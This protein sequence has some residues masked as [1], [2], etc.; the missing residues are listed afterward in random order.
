MGRN[1]ILRLIEGKQTEV[2][3]TAEEL[4]SQLRRCAMDLTAFNLPRLENFYNLEI[5]GSRASFRIR[6]GDVLNIETPGGGGF[7]FPEPG[8]SY[9]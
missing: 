6:Y 8:D 9:S 7:G 4:F 1:Q 5:L 3:T 2:G